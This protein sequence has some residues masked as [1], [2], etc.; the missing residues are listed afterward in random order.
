VVGTMMGHA[1]YDS[2]L[3]PVLR[4]M[5][6]VEAHFVGLPEQGRLQRALWRT[7]PWLGERDL[8]FQQSRWHA[9]HARLARKVLLEE[10]DSFRPDVVHVRSHS[11]ALAMRS[12]MS[13]VPIVPVVDTTVWDW[14]SMAIWRP[15]RGHSRR[16]LWWSEH[17]ERDLFRCAPLVLAMN[18]WAKAAIERDAP[19]ANVVYHHPGVD[20]DRFQPG[21]R[22]GSDM[23]RVLFVGGRFAEKGGLD[24]IAALD[25]RLGRD[26][27]LDVVTAEPVPE[28][29]G[30]MVHQLSNDDPR[31][32]ELY[33]RADVFCLP[34]H[35]DTNPWVL[36]EAMACG[37]PAIA[38]DMAG[39]P[40]LLAGGEAGVLIKPGDRHGLRSELDALLDHEPRRRELG[41]RARAYVE[42]RFDARK[43]VPELI[44]LLR[45]VANRQ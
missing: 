21:Q 39:I 16:V 33:Q 3:V 13:R 32:V 43:R 38:S 8:D 22:D 23:R 44:D 40:E 24:L 4:E 18:S 15:V 10:L 34:T 26:T 19:S 30:I 42:E 1:T 20:L 12:L 37:T 7:L 17:A 9:V 45:G 25:G 29:D 27:Q 6:D 11:M 31:L 36:L 5:P 2:S 41:T 14:R 28:R 35:G